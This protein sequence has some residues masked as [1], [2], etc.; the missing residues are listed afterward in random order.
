MYHHIA[1]VYSELDEE[2][3]PE[4]LS[5]YNVT[6]SGGDTLEICGTY[7]TSSRCTRWPLFHFYRLQDIAGINAQVIKQP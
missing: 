1:A 5:I 3:K 6:K 2:R 4:I 7:T